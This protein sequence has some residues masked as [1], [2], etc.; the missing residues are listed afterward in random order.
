MRAGPITTRGSGQTTSEARCPRSGWG[1]HFAW[2]RPRATTADR[3]NSNIFFG[4]VFRRKSCAI[5]VIRRFRS[6][7]ESS[8]MVVLN[9]YFIYAFRAWFSYVP[10]SLDELR[11]KNL[12]VGTSSAF[13]P[14]RMVKYSGV[15]L[16]IS[17]LLSKGDIVGRL[18]ALYGGLCGYVVWCSGSSQSIAV[19]W[20]IRGDRTAAL[21]CIEESQ[22]LDGSC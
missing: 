14:A 22:V 16:S 9:F 20:Q 11:S 15:D 8:A 3:S 19:F 17:S 21:Y 4:T 12:K 5:R 18:K 6:R 1:T 10:K 2:P 7:F 13:C